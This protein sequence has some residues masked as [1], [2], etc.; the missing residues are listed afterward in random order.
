[1]QVSKRFV[2]LIILFFAFSNLKAQ[3]N[4][5]YVM[6]VVGDEGS[7]E[8][9]FSGALLFE[10]NRCFLLTN[11]VT[12]NFSTKSQAFSFNCIVAP[13]IQ[14]LHLIAYPNPFKEKVVIKS[15][16]LFDFNT[17]VMYNLFLYSPSGVLLKTY[18]TSI[19][20]LRSGFEI[21]AQMY[22]A[23]IYYLKIQVG[24]Q[25]VETLQLIKIQ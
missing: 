6:G 18:S 22:D 3:I 17:S 5:Q 24:K 19:Y 14:P 7:K 12:N 11:G 10:S 8:Q 13:A 9:F 15:R 23:G 21:S 25:L 20:G 2:S 4:M 16:S 1:M